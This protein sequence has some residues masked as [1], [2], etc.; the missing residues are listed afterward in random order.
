M[1]EKEWKDSGKIY[2]ERYILRDKRQKEITETY[3]QS[4]LFD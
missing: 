1:T 2:S 4:A 3:I